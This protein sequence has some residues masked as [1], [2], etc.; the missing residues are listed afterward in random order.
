MDFLW[1]HI[2]VQ[3]P[4]A[5]SVCFTISN[6][7]ILR[8]RR[9]RQRTRGNTAATR[10]GQIAHNSP[11][12]DVCAP[13]PLNRLCSIRGTGRDPLRVPYP[14][15]PGL[16]L[17]R[18]QT[19]KHKQAN[20]DVKGKR[21]DWR[22][23]FRV[24][25]I[26]WVVDFIWSAQG[27]PC[28]TVSVSWTSRLR[29]SPAACMYVCTVQYHCIGCPNRSLAHVKPWKLNRGGCESNP[30]RTRGC[31]A[32]CASGTVPSCPFSSDPFPSCEKL[33]WHGCLSVVMNAEKE[34]GRG[35]AYVSVFSRWMKYLERS[36]ENPRVCK[37][38]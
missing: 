9:K 33:G 4:E 28:K 14:V 12:G 27:P 20:R 24:H 37:Q 26:R 16:H 36:R 31:A 29:P 1:G 15:F 3:L 10:R 25:H 21:L 11:G 6:R 2:R 8:W 13:T 30:E 23:S 38:I 22:P 34:A 5:R 19:Q 32:S 7:V 18:P 17:A 35:A